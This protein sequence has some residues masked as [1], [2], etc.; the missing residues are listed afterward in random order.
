[1]R[2][3]GFASFY[4]ER[5]DLVLFDDVE[6][7]SLVAEVVRAGL[8]PAVALNTAEQP[9]AQQALLTTNILQKKTSLEKGN[10][11]KKNPLFNILSKKD[12]IQRHP[13]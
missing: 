7:G 5:F 13:S 3:M 9:H 6:N 2:N 11:Q 12:F 4:S 1:M 10:L 8:D